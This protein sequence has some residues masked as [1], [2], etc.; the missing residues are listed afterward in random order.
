ME[1]RNPLEW[2]L[3]P[4]YANNCFSVKPRDE[5]E[6][7]AATRGPPIASECEQPI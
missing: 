4:L 3:F 7:G 5:R 1:R 2:K 6:F